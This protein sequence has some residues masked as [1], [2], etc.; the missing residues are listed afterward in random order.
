MLY[1]R[2]VAGG[3]CAVRL[4]NR[5]PRGVVDDRLAVRRSQRRDQCRFGESVGGSQRRRPQTEARADRRELG[6]IAVVDGFG[7]VHRD[8]Q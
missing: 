1:I 2:G 7:S 4:R 6:H 3:L 5:L 8:A